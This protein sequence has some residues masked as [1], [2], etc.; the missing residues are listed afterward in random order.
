MLI[1][2]FLF[3]L[4]PLAISAGLHFTG[5]Y[6]RDWRTAD[7]SSVGLLKPAAETPGAVI[8]IF[9]ARTVVTVALPAIA[10]S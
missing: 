6:D 3:F 7:R 10:G 8:R 4:L 9:A 1:A 5:D 2:F